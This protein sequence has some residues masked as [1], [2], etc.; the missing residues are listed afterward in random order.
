[1]FSSCNNTQYT[2][3]CVVNFGISLEGGFVNLMLPSHWLTRFAVFLMAYPMLFLQT[4]ELVGNLDANC[5]T[6]VD[7]LDIT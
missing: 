4:G 7:N 3:F 6:N 5:V 2:L 1:M